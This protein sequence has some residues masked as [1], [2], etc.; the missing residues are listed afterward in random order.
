MLKEEGHSLT[1]SILMRL[2]DA[3]GSG[4]APPAERPVDLTQMNG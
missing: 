3:V 1:A 4:A 2:G